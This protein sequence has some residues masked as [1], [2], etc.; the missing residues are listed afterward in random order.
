MTICT[1]GVLAGI[2]WLLETQEGHGRSTG[3]GQGTSPSGEKDEVG[4]A[5]VV[6]GGSS[7]KEGESLRKEPEVK[8]A[9]RCVE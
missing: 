1:L 3:W 7:G 4:E 8:I 9:V 2:H 6:K 5:E